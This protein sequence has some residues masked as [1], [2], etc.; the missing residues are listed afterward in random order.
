MFIFRHSTGQ[1]PAAMEFGVLGSNTSPSNHV[2]A[3]DCHV[4][5]NE[6]ANFAVET[7]T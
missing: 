7:V 2:Y 1:I 5:T 4:I 6:S 3:V